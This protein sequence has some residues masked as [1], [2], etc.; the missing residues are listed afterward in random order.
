MNGLDI[1]LIGAG[2]VGLIFA[3][4][5]MLRRGGA[6]ELLPV[7]AGCV[8]VILVGL[9]GVL[10]ALWLMI[11]GGILL[12]GGFIFERQAAKASS[13]QPQKPPQE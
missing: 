5:T 4:I 2:F 10:E 8:G 11:I 9:G 13:P 1:L 7:T 6:R 12:A 3:I